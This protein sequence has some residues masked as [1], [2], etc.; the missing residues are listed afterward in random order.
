MDWFLYDNGLRHERVNTKINTNVV[1][2]ETKAALKRFTK[3][4]S[5]SVTYL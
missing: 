3:N 1:T 5:A 2:M 4:I